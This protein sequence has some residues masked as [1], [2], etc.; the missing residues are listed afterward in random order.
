VCAGELSRREAHAAEL[1]ERFKKLLPADYFARTAQL[2]RYCVSVNQAFL[3]LVV[4]VRGCVGVPARL[5]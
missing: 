2:T 5:R 1:P 3:R 4:Q